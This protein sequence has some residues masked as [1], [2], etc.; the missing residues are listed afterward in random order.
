MCQG[1]RDLNSGIRKML[2]VAYVHSGCHMYVMGE[3]LFVLP[4]VSSEAVFR[5]TQW[6]AAPSMFRH[7]TAALCMN[8]GYLL[9][10]V[11]YP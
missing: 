4:A 10:L 3:D 2:N 5:M 9:N 11:P 1:E 7:L 6:V 8:R